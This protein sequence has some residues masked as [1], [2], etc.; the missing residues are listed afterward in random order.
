MNKNL[1]PAAAAAAAAYEPVQKHK[2]TPSILGWLNDYYLSFQ[3]DGNAYHKQYCKQA[4]S[5]IDTNTFPEKK[6]PSLRNC[7]HILQAK[8]VYLWYEY[9]DECWKFPS[10][11]NCYHIQNSAV[12]TRSIFLK[13]PK[14]HTTQ[15]AR[16]G[17]VWGIFCGSSILLTF[18]P[19]S[20]KHLVIYAIYYCIGPRYN[21][22]RL[23][24]RLKRSVYV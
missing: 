20:C 22:T 13:I 3:V 6:N 19:S 21:G 15:L 10:R 16:S 1:R 17:D 5:H 8:T 9:H 11:R 18:C 12:V 2:V 24:Y 23:Y 14:T 7:Y 4:L